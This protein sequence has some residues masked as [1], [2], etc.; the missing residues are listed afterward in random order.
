MLALGA[1]GGR[2]E[3]KGID[4]NSYQGDRAIISLFERMGADIKRTE[5]GVICRKNRLRGINIDASQIPDLVPVL[6]TVSA[7]ADGVTTIS[8]AERLRLK[9]SDRL[10]A[11]THCLKKMG[12]KIEQTADGLRIEGVERLEG[13]VKLSGFGDHRIVM[14]L[15]VAA[16][17][18]LNPITITDADSVKKSWP[19]FF[20][21]YKKCGGAVDVI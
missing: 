9:E 20:E 3:L 13:G 8:G 6:A 18:C 1:V 21:E 10:E 14:S 5:G 2:L 4:M 11:I 16:L 12:A 15:A 19:S 7:L 17:G